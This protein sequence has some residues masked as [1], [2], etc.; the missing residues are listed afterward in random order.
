MSSRP[1]GHCEIVRLKP[2]QS[3]LRGLEPFKSSCLASAQVGTF[4]YFI[5]ETTVPVSSTHYRERSNANSVIDLGKVLAGIQVPPEDASAF[6]DFL[7][8]L[9]YPYV[10]ETGNEVYKRYLRE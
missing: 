6:E 2:S 3:S 10:E 9:G 8:N 4:H 5:T 7:G 1:L